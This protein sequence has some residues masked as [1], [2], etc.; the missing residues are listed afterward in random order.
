[1]KRF[2]LFVK[3]ILI[4]CWSLIILMLRY[5]WQKIIWFFNHLPWIF[6]KLNRILRVC[7]NMLLDIWKFFLRMIDELG[8][9]PKAVKCIGMIIA[10]LIVFVVLDKLTANFDEGWRGFFLVFPT[11]AVIGGCNA[12]LS[13]R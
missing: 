2:L 3:T 8:K 5:F 12:V 7:L 1:M 13:K 9:H 6:G 11:L 10:G 4:R